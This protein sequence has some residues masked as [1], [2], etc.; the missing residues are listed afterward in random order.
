MNNHDLFGMSFRNLWRRKTRTLLTML[1]VVIGT[2]SIVVMISL[3]IAMDVGFQEQL[4]QMGEL[5]IIEVNNYGERSVSAQSSEP[6]KLDDKAVTYFRSIAGVEAVMPVKSIYVK[7]AIGK[8]VSHV[9]LIGIDPSIQ[10]AFGFKIGEGRLLQVGDKEA[11]LFGEYISQWFYNPRSRFYEETNVNLVTDKLIVTNNMS[12]GDRRSSEETGNSNQ[13]EYKV[14]NARGVGQL[15][16]S[17]DYKDYNA[18][19]SL[20]F[21]EELIREQESGGG[22][23]Y[24]GQDSTQYETIRVK[25]AKID[26]VEAVND[27]IRAQGYATFSYIDISKEMKKT[28]GLIQAILGGIGAISLLVA[29]I[30]IANTMVM[31]IYERTREIG[32]MKVLGARLDDIRSMF[33]LEAALIGLGGGL[34]GIGLSYGVSWIMNSAGGSM[35]GNFLGMY[36]AQRISVIPWELALIAVAFSTAVGIIAGYSPA[37]RAMKLSAL[38]AI[39]TE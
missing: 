17:N 32:V 7:M 3:G 26:D 28:S 30:G 14:H 25:V 2:A 39:K 11:V 37:R 4:A 27:T 29:A 20:A 34:I 13:K 36:G 1:G 6:L 18:F 16:Q 5:N 10:E 15:A 35:L 12:Y 9:G 21:V 8:Y 23:D 31:S 24:Y 22:R 33:L 38:E 19:A